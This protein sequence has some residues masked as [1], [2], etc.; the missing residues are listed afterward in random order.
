MYLLQVPVQIVHA[1]GIKL[2]VQLSHHIA[3]PAPMS[4]DI[5]GRGEASHVGHP[6]G[7]SGDDVFRTEQD[8]RLSTDQRLHGA[9]KMRSNAPSRK[10]RVHHLEDPSA[11]N[12]VLSNLLSSNVSTASILSKKKPLNLPT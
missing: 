3:Q 6:V 5:L 9:A 10:C 8:R 1:F 7:C 2:S 11:C 4:L 12:C